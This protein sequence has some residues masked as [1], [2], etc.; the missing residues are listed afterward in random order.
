MGILSNMN[1]LDE[2]NEFPR[3]RAAFSVDGIATMFG[4]LLGLSPVTSYIESASGVSVGARTGLTSCFVGIFFM[5]GIFFSPLIASIPPWATGGALI[6]VGSM[7]ARS[8]ADVKWDNIT[9]A[10]TAFITVIVMPLT[11]SIAYGLIAGICMWIILEGTFYLLSLVGI[12][13]PDM[14]HT[15]I[16]EAFDDTLGG[17]GDKAAATKSKGDVEK[18]SNESEENVIVDPS[19]AAGTKDKAESEEETA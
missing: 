9:H 16:D 14:D 19:A 13:R 2:K 15:N 11:Y 18:D 12:A 1:L 3:A 6:L 5:L 4:S 7:M 17:A 8:L 10:A